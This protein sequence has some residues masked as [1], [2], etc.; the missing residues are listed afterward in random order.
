MSH[1]LIVADGI[2]LWLFAVAA[3]CQSADSVFSPIVKVDALTVRSVCDEPK[4]FV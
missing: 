3:E 1:A 2:T 4:S